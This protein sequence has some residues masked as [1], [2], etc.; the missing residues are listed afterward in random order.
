RANRAA[1]CARYMLCDAP[2]QRSR[3][4][5]LETALDHR[6]YMTILKLDEDELRNRRS[7]FNLTDEDLARL[8]SLRSFAEKAMDG[9]VDAFYEL[10]LNHPDTRK[11]F[12]DEVAVRRVKR[13]QKEYFLGL[14]TGRC[15]L[16]YVEDRLRVGA[17]HERIGLAPKWYLGAYRQYLQ[18]IL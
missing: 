11:F 6:K 7:S 16:A 17:I 4:M 12:P 18:L 10:L 8:A 5:P 1:S 13:T 3:L 14:F 2:K 9:I 15:D